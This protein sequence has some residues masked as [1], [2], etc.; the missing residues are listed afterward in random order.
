MLSR[1]RHSIVIPAFNEEKYLPRLLRSIGEARAS[2]REGADA[3]EVIVADNDSTD[4]TAAVAAAHGCRVQRVEKRVIA[5]ARN[6]GARAASGELLSFVD[7]DTLSIHPD[8]FD[9]IDELMD[10]GRYVAG[11]TGIRLERWSPGIAATY[12]L[13]LPFVWATGM[14]TGVVFCRREDWSA[15]G[16]YDERRPIAEDVAFLWALRRLG[17]RRGQRLVRASSVKAMASTRK[18]DEHGDWHYLTMMPRVALRAAFARD[19][20]RKMIDRYWYRPGR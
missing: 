20:G 5:A 7:A 1:P 19:G 6:G 8:T 13:L 15:A 14:D 3:V 17:A 16:G 2:Y 10:T 9:V 11:S 12:L 4:G 18:F